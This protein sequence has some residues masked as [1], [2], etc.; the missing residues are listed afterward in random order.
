M[1]ILTSKSC[2]DKKNGI[3]VRVIS[4][5]ASMLVAVRKSFRQFSASEVP[6][7]KSNKIL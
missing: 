1:K 3:I 5:P 4:I 2:I 7:P 6:Y